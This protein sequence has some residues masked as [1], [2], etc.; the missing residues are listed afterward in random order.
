MLRII[1]EFEI[2]IEDIKAGALAL[3]NPLKLSEI[4][5]INL[6]NITEPTSH[7]LIL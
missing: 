2:V 6:E 7:Y 5:K 3:Y 4:K 1:S